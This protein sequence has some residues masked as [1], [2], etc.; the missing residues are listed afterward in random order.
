M[1][2]G[3]RDDITLRERG[4]GEGVFMA[5]VLFHALPGSMIFD[6]EEVEFES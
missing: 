1:V 5:L 2:G 4:R 6:R 3:A